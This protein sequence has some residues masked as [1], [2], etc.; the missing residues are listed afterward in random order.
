MNNRLFNKIR[1]VIFMVKEGKY[2]KEQAYDKIV[3]AMDI[4]SLGAD[5]E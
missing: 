1:A 2:T 5:N 3:N 4:N